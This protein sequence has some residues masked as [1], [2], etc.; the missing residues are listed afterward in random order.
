[1]CKNGLREFAVSSKV[2]LQATK[3]TASA[4]IIM[5]FFLTVILDLSGNPVGYLSF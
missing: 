4:K 1:L 5:R 2:G 3:N